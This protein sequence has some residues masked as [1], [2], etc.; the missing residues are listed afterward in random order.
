MHN[1]QVAL[2]LFDLRDEF[3]FNQF[4]LADAKREDSLE[5]VR[6]L[7]DKTVKFLMAADEEAA[8]RAFRQLARTGAKQVYVLAGGIPAWRELFANASS[9]PAPRCS[10]APLVAATPPAIPT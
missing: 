10:L 3:A 6:A 5:S 8:L 4:H 1:R 7:P 2:A 9:G